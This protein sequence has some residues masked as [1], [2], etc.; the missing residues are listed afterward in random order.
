VSPRPHPY[1]RRVVGILDLARKEAERL[2][3]AYTGPEHLL[4]ALL[5]E[6]GGGGLLA[7]RGMKVSLD[8]LYRM[9]CMCSTRMA[10]GAETA[11][12]LTAPAR[13]AM[14]LAEEEARQLGHGYI[15]TE[16][17]LL[18]VLR[19]QWGPI[20]MVLRD[21]GVTLEAM[22]A[23]VRALAASDQHLDNSLA[24]RDAARTFRARVTPRPGY[25][26]QPGAAP[27][28]KLDA[29]APEARAVLAAAHTAA[30]RANRAAIAPEHLLL[31]LLE[32]A[33]GVPARALTSLGGDPARLRAALGARAAR[34]A[35]GAGAGAE[36]L[37]L[38]PRTKA[39]VERAL[40]EA[41]RE[42]AGA[43][44]PGHLLRALAGEREG[45]AVAALR[46]AGLDPARVA[47]RTREAQREDA[48]TRL[49]WRAAAD[50]RTA[51]R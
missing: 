43:V 27:T 36:T 35:V 38:A 6:Q 5:R 20:A 51:R 40:M 17:V 31:A 28:P 11:E 15:G 34:G 24:G 29:F 39:L 30:W 8:R 3:C 46:Q 33:D 37:P 25:P 18:G 14:A 48:A 10:P 4:L 9:I 22:R 16:H 23:Q 21:A 1:T 45:V 47:A 19:A 2:N 32:P 49:P 42:H 13:R 7:L 50:K 12:Q 44:A 26:Y 41:R